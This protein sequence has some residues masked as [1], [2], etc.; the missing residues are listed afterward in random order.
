MKTERI[1][2][3]AL[4]GFFVAVILSAFISLFRSIEYE[5]KI[6]NLTGALHN[7]R[8]Q[9]EIINTQITHD[10]KKQNYDEVQQKWNVFD[11]NWRAF[12]QKT[13]S[14]IHNEPKIVEQIEILQ[15]AID[16]KYQRIL[17]FES[18]KAVLNNS[19]F[20]L[21]DLK[22]DIRQQNRKETELIADKLGELL[23]NVFYYSVNQT[24][25]EEEIA[26]L[27]GLLQTHSATLSETDILLG[28]LRMLAT[29]NQEITTTLKGINELQVA[30]QFESLESALME[31]VSRERSY[32]RVVNT[33]IALFV[34]I[35]L[36]GFVNTFLKTYRDKYKILKLQEE[37]D[38]KHLEVVQKMQLLNEYKRA[39]D[40]S[41]IV[42]KT[43]LNGI[44]T[45]VNER[46]CTISGYTK[47]ELIGEPH[48]II[49][50]PDFPSSVFKEL[51]GALHN[52]QVFHGII[53]NRKKS[54]EDYFVDS[55]VVPIVDEY[56]NPIEYIAI[57]NDVT[58]LIHAKDKAIA[59]EQAKS[60]FFANMSHELRTPLNAII[61]F[62]QILM[63]KSDTPPAVKVFV[64]KIH[65][66]GK[67]LLEMVNTILDFSKMESGMME[68]TIDSFEMQD[69]I[70]EV[71][72]L[73]ESMAEKK[74]ITLL[75]DLP[76]SISLDAD[77]QLLKQ[78]LV[79]L[80]SNAIKFSPESGSIV[81]EFRKEEGWNIVGV[82]DFGLGINQDQIETLFNPFTQIR[83]HQKGAVK[84]TGLGLA[85][86]KKIIDLHNGKIWVESTVGE[87]SCFYI[88]LPDG[89]YR[90]HAQ[91]PSV[92]KQI[93]T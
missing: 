26:E 51:W 38:Q 71:K 68:V 30:Q 81:L 91:E 79:N 86:V 8:M 92:E 14:D 29:K 5:Q 58:E 2:I 31:T 50:H 63:A 7:L 13:F 57:R 4:I 6:Y 74:N 93:R 17:H 43:D 67:N 47:E 77:R 42:S 80:L 52:R 34:V 36:I 78:V 65:I 59:A 54:G 3:L 18:D 39:L 40:E 41:S 85:I 87:G 37:N 21:L 62:S 33:L 70:K 53:R 45:Y 60:A 84:G 73:V 48:N 25:L 66:A 22:H 23:N 10:F 24:I 82:R 9:N 89:K 20:F 11:E 1:R 75:M 12:R 46:F 64:D 56:D 72:I 32:Y 16:S 83:E 44:I 76:G 69:L 55:T 88:A 35:T 28:H 15:K 61:G 19:L 27:A 49:R 90:V